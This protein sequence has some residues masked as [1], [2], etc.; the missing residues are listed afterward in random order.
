M[1]M[2]LDSSV[3][4]ASERRGHDVVQILEQIETAHG[5]TEIGISV[6]TV[7]EL[8]HGA[9]RTKSDGDRL[10]RLAFI[11][12]LCRDVAVHPLSLAIAKDIGRIAG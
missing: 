6:V 1:G 7:A 12:E 4:V 2:I 11:D 9:Y 8:T 5:E 3:I 10:R